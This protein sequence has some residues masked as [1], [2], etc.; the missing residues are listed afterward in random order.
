[1][2]EIG[3]K[4][5]LMVAN[6][7]KSG[8][9][10]QSEDGDE[11]FLPGSMAPRDLAV[12]QSLVVFVYTDTQGSRIATPEI[13]LAE[14]DSFAYL[15]VKD[16]TDFGAFFDW[17]ISKDLLVPGNQQKVKV[18]LGEYHLVRICLEPE[19]GR[20]FG[21]TKIGAYTETSDVDLKE[22][23]IVDIL[24]FKKT[25]L[26][27]QVLI[28]EKYMG[29]LYHNEVFSKIT[30]GTKTKGIIK[31]VRTDG[32]VDVS[33]Q[34]QGMK[35]LRD[36][37]KTILQALEK[38]NGTLPLTDKSDPRD[39]KYFLGM[40]KQTFKRAVGMLYREKKVFLKKASIELNTNA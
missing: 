7:T 11:V 12:G 1:M 3:K 40:S 15:R 5:A 32:L 35:N 19:T 17:G 22:K 9:T 8:F 37:S 14:V 6:E 18:Q 2:I 34:A 20:L 24:P 30:L 33:L 25:S 36:S 4:T 13:P 39:I 23:D 38:Y 28:E 29:M 31:K 26:G 10:L 27:I 16:V 21:T